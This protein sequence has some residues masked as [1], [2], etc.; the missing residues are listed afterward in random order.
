MER[1]RHR[2]ATHRAAVKAWKYVALLL[3]LIIPVFDALAANISIKANVHQTV[4]ASDNEFLTGRSSGSATSSSTST[5][6]GR[7]G[8]SGPTYKS[9]TTGTFD[10]LAQTPTTKYLLN[11]SLNY[12]SYLGPGAEDTSLRWGTPAN[13]RFTIDHTDKL[14]TYN[15]GASWSRADTAT[16]TLAE[17]GN[18][19]GRGYTDTYNVFGSLTHDLSRLDTVTWSANGSTASF[20]DQTTPYLDVS[21]TFAWRH[22]LTQLTTLNSSVF[23]D[24]YSQDN[25]AESQRLFWRLQSGVKSQLSH[26]LTFN[27]NVGVAFVNAY[28]NGIAQAS[29]PTSSTDSTPFQVQVGAA[30]AVIGDV[31]LTYQASKTTTVSLR[32]AESITPTITGQL[33]QSR[34]VGL[35]TNHQINELSSLSASAQFAQTSSSNEGDS[36]NSTNPVFYSASVKYSYKLT[37]NWSAYISYTYRQRDDE[38]G[39][40][41]SNTI[42]FALTRDFNVLGN[43]TLIDEAKKERARERARQAVGQV[44]PLY[45]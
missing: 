28:Q 41:N 27:G 24:W 30:N 45:Q 2:C 6:S 35:S 25:A 5:S 8:P 14:N 11:T 40:T 38:T 20:T 26:R 22:N 42:L 32:A 43:P 34:T 10:F 1:A 19:T 16:T 31:G 17:T 4:T 12:F 23:F 33:Q 7:N 18:A 9:S 36:S 39:A 44:F 29:N 15:F 3:S 13:T 37:R 21:S